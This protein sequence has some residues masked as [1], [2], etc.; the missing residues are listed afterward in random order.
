[1]ILLGMKINSTGKLYDT[2]FMDDGEKDHLPNYSPLVQVGVSRFFGNTAISVHL[3]T[4]LFQWPFECNSFT[5]DSGAVLNLCRLLAA[6]T[7]RRRNAIARMLC[8]GLI[9]KWN[10]RRCLTPLFV[11]SIGFAASGPMQRSIN[12]NI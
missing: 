2:A 11:V 10:N 4:D 9:P 7:A 8:E 3:S 12:Q 1:M 5:R 6:T